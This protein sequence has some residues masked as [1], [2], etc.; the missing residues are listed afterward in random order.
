M[1]SRDGLEVGDRKWGKD[2]DEQCCHYLCTVLKQ[3]I[4]SSL[5]Q[6]MSLVEIH[7]KIV[8]LILSVSLTNNKDVKQLFKGLGK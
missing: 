3:K 4:Q 5:K 6:A 2:W 8:W 1:E 7:G